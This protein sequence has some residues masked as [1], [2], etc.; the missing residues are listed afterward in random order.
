M[1]KVLGK[2]FYEVEYQGKKYPKVRY[3][4]GL[5]D[6]VIRQRG[7]RDVQGPICDTV[8]LKNNQVNS[9]PKIGD[10]VVVSYDVYNGQKKPNG[11]FII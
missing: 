8:T 9:K 1:H 3:T 4:L 10:T 7:F 2:A 5:S 11:I 6:E